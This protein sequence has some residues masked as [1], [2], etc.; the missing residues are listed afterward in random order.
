MQ[1]DLK[2]EVTYIDEVKNF[3]IV[4]EKMNDDFYTYPLGTNMMMWLDDDGLIGEIECIFPEQLDREVFLIKKQEILMQNGFPLI[5]TEVPVEV[6]IA[7]V[8]KRKDYFTLYFSK[9]ETYNKE[10]VATILTFYVNDNELVAV[11][12]ELS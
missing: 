4:T 7:K 9:L 8:F 3:D 5:N 11:K 6:S 2:S 1:Q 12:A 10:I